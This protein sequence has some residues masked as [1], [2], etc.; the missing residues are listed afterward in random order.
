M[1]EVLVDTLVFCPATALAI[2]ASVDSVGSY[3]TG[4]EL[5]MSSVGSLFNGADV[6]L[7]VCIFIFAYATVICWFYYGTLAVKYLFQRGGG[8]FAV[9]YTIAVFLGAVLDDVIAVKITDVLLLILTF[10]TGITLIKRSGSLVML[11][12]REG[13]IKPRL[14]CQVRPSSHPRI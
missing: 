13:L 9:F 12:E 2:L 11:S 8:V 7:A 14:K 5:I 1:G 6:I 10:I 4:I 3:Q